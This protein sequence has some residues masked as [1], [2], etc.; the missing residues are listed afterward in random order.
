MTAVRLDEDLLRRVDRERRKAQLSRARVIS[1]AL[2]M[3][4]ERRRVEAAIRAD[5]EG[6]ARH[7]V[8]GDEFSPVL[9]GQQWPK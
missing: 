7:P 6:Y 9:G 2:A 5:H 1:E 8:E 3:W 4:L